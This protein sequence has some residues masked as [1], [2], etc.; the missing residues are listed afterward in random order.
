MLRKKYETAFLFKKIIQVIGIRYNIRPDLEDPKDAEA[1]GLYN[2]E[3]TAGFF[4]AYILTPVHL[5]LVKILNEYGFLSMKQLIYYGEKFTWPGTDINK[6][7]YECVAYG[8][9]YRN[10][11][12]FN[13]NSTIDIF[14]L[15]TGGYFT[16]EE[17]GIKQNKQLYTLGIDERLTMYRKA[18]YL[19]K[20]NNPSLKGICMLED[21]VNDKD[22]E[23]HAGR[24]VLFD[25]KIGQILNLEHEVQLKIN[26]LE[27]NGARVVDI[28]K[29]CGFA[30][31][32]S[33]QE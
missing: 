32:A 33:A 5:G 18:A 9:M 6:V 15:D 23:P 4:R 14:G 10:H 19:T 28:S 20:E 13:N 7:L 21:I 3:T 12:L 1:A 22:F 25:S 27:K 31:D 29:E 2:K 17:V 26:Q 8:L 11:V 30:L 16:L 24:I